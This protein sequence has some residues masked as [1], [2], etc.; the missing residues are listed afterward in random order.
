MNAGL[1]I[2]KL[3]SKGFT[4]H[5]SCKQFIGSCGLLF[6]SS[7]LV[8]HIHH[9]LSLV[10]LF[11]GSLESIIDCSLFCP[12][13]IHGCLCRFFPHTHFLTQCLNLLSHFG[14]YRPG[15]KCASDIFI[16][17]QKCALTLILLHLGDFFLKALHNSL[18]SFFGC[19][20]YCK[21]TRHSGC[22]IDTE[23]GNG[24][25]QHTSNLFIVLYHPSS[26]LYD[27]DDCV[28]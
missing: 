24:S 23:S 6:R 20:L 22:L 26:T 19:N 28:L 1:G 12:C 7:D 4:L 18:A 2:G 17:C 21:F 27:L 16:K 15:F 10:N 13:S 11:I 8:S 3:G 9:F 25:S 14:R 5:L